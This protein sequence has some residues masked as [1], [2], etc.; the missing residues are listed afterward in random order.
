MQS[1]ITKGDLVEFPT[2]DGFLLNGFLQSPKKAKTCVIYVHGMG[3]TFYGGSLR[4]A[5]G[6]AINAKNVAFFAINTRGHDVIA[7]IR[8]N[9]ATIKSAVI[10]VNFERFEDCIQDIQGAINF[11]RGQGFDRIILSGASTG[12]QK[13]TFY[14]YKKNNKSVIGLVLLAPGDDY[15]ISKKRLG[16]KFD[17]TVRL[18]KNMVGKRL[19][20][21]VVPSLEA[22]SGFSAR[23]FLSFADPKNA[24]ARLFNFDGKLREFSRIRVPVCAIIGSLDDG[25]V[26]P[27]RVYMK[28]LERKTGSRFFTYS[29]IRGAR[30]SFIGHE[31]DAASIVA[32]FVSKI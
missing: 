15:N 13:I 31:D 11:M 28:A 10:G 12:C 8:R 30:H 19:G 17:R 9:K 5:L 3:G 16:T 29:I 4:P 20:N 6:R 14:Q 22:Y 23:R 27:V 25:R 2:P 21:D 24:E 32:D 7:R 18:C 1:S 26:K